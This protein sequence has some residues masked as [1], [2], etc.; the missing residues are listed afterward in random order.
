[1][2]VTNSDIFSVSSDTDD[3]EDEQNVVDEDLK[4]AVLSS[5]QTE[6]KNVEVVFIS[7]CCQK[8][9]KYTTDTL[10]ISIFFRKT[11][12]IRSISDELEER[13]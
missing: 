2:K 3:G 13:I 9:S 4:D 7:L 8:R 11:R 6:G 5:F 1:M 12:I 10:I